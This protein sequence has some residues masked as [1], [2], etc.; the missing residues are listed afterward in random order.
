MNRVYISFVF[1]GFIGLILLVHS[2]I[3]ISQQR[4]LPAADVVQEAQTPRQVQITR[5]EQQQ[6]P[7]DQ[8][9]IF[10]ATKARPS[11]TAFETQPDQGKMLGFDFARDPVN[12]KEPMQPAEEIMKNDVGDKPK[13]TAA[14]QQLLDR[15]Y[16]LAPRLD[17]SAKM[18][19]GKPLA[20]GPT[21]RLQGTTWQNLAKMIPDEI[22]HPMAPSR[23][24]PFVASK[25]VRHTF[26]TG[27]C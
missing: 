10:S 7:H 27:G 14:Q 24:L 19:R 11:S 15:R 18:S 22:R 23:P 1:I 20:V 2:S 4:T 25:I 26:M 13:V 9:D 21:A 6:T 16:D 5:P 17:P 8:S 12:A 3:G